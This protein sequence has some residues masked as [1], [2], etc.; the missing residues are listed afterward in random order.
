MWI[1]SSKWL[2]FQN[3]S[4]TSSTNVPQMTAPVISNQMN[5]FLISCQ[6][7][8]LILQTYIVMQQIS[9]LFLLF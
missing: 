4:Q 2:D 6:F 7:V 1:E 3:S 5:D 9:C 8:M